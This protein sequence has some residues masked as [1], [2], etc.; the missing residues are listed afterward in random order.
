MKKY[1]LETLRLSSFP[2]HMLIGPDEKIMRVTN[3]I[4]DLELFIREKAGEAK[5]RN[6]ARRG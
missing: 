4:E 3:S 2:T 1:M 5:K 6:R